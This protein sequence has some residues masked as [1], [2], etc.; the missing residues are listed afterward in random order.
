M[1]HKIVRM[2]NWLEMLDDPE[3]I[4]APNF[5]SDYL[6]FDSVKTSELELLCDLANLYLKVSKSHRHICWQAG[7]LRPCSSK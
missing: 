4:W 5:Q 3:P 1:V 7:E 2:F 6:G